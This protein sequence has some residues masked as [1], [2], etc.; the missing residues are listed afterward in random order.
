MVCHWH[1]VHPASLESARVELLLESM[2]RYCYCSSNHFGPQNLRNEEIDLI[3]IRACIFTYDQK[4]RAM[5]EFMNSEF[6]GRIS[7]CENHITTQRIYCIR[8]SRICMHR[9]VSFFRSM[10]L[11][12]NRS[13]ILLKIQRQFLRV[14]ACNQQKFILTQNHVH[15][16][17]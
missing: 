8:F 17:V 14:F 15:D 5:H 4:K 12:R 10:K 13:F 3:K 1:I 7:R 9:K 16:L 6:L 2:N 11:T